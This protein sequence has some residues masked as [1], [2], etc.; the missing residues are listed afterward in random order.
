MNAVNDRGS[1]CDVL[2]ELINTAKLTP[3]AQN[4]YR[5]AIFCL[6]QSY[7]SQ[8]VAP[9]GKPGLPMLF[10]WPVLASPEYVDLLRRHQAIA[11]VI[12]AYYA[13][14]LHR[15]RDMWL[16]AGSGHFLIKCISTR[17]GPDWREWLKLP[18]EAIREK[19]G[20]EI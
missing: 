7:N 17:L 2:F 3:L 4:A 8:Y 9:G 19:P 14:L 12:L 5:D 16:V 13:V 11:L 15:G 18:L 6:Q 10:A 20:A 1:E